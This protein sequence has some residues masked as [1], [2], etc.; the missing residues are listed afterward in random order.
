M[1][2]QVGVIKQISGL[3]VAVDQNGVSRVLK[4]GDAL[5]LG[6]V[7]KTSLAS[8]KAVV[9][10]DNGKDVTILGDESLKLDENVVAGQKP[11]TV[12]D[13]ID[14]Q[15]ALLN[16]EDL[17][18]LEETAAGGNAAAAGG[19]DG[20]SL[21]AASFDEGGHYS[22][23][24]ENFRSIGD[25]NSARGA[26][27]IGGVSGAADNAVGDAGFV[28]TTTPTVTLDPINN[29]STVVTGK[30]PNP[31]P[32]TTVTVEIPGHT[33]VTVPVNPDGTFS[34][35]TPNNEPLKPGT[36]VKVT[37]N[38]DAGNGTPATTP[39]SDV[40]TPTVTLDPINNTSTVVTGK[41]P[42]PD[43]N[44]TVTVEIPGHTPVTVPVNPDGTFSVPTPNNEP[45]KPGTEVKV[46]P[47][48]DAGNGTPAT[49]PVS[50]VVPPQVDLTPKADGTVDVV[51]HDNDATKVEISYTDNNGN[52]QT[53]TVVKNSSVGWVVDNTPGKTTAPTGAFKL[54]PNSG[55]VTISDDAT[56]DNTPVTAKATDSAGN[57]ATGE[58]TAPDK[59]TI[60]FNDD[61]DGNGTITR[62]ENYAEDGVKATATI[63][64]PNL[65]KDG[66]KIHVIGT[67]I[68][69]YYTVHKDASGNVTSVI[70]TK[71]NNVFDGNN[72]IKVGYN[73]NHYQTALGNA[74][75]ITAELEGTTLKATSS[76]KFENVKMADVEFVE[77]DKNGNVL[78]DMKTGNIDTTRRY[79]RAT[80]ALDGDINH[81]TAR[82]SLPDN[83]QD[84]DVITVKYGFGPSA[85]SLAATGGTDT[86]AYKYFLVHKAAD[87]SMTVDQIT[88]ADDKT[89]IKAGLT[90]TNGAGEK[91][92][93]DIH[94]M[95]TANYDHTHSRGIEVKITGE[96][97]S[98]VG[99]NSRYISRESMQA[100]T[101][102]FVE[103]SEELDPAIVGDGGPGSIGMKMEY[104]GLDG[105]IHHTT[106]RIKL[107]SIF[108]DGDKLTVA[109]T[110]YNK[111][112]ADTGVAKYPGDNP[113]PTT[114]KT[115][116]IHKAAD[117]TVTFDEVDASGNVIRAGIPSVNNS[118]IDVSEI[119]LYS[120]DEAGF[121]HAT[122]VDATITDHLNLNGNDSASDIA[123]YVFRETVNVKDV[124][125]TTVHDDFGS[126][127]GDISKGG[128]TDDKTPELIGKADKFATIEIFDGTHSLGTTT[129]DK[130]GNWSFTPSTPL[131]DGE[132]KFTAKATI[133]GSSKTSGEY[134][135][136]IDTHVSI[137]L[138]SVDIVADSS[139]LPGAGT[140]PF[141]VRNLTGGKMPLSDHNDILNVSGNVTGG[142][143]VLAGKGNDKISIGGYLGGIL[144]NKGTINLGESDTKLTKTVR[145][146]V[147]SDEHNREF[148]IKDANDH[149]IGRA[150]TDANGKFDGKV[151]LT[152]TISSN[153]KIS[154]EI[155]D[156]VGNTASDSKMTSHIVNSDGTRYYNNELGI[157]TD[158]D[159]GTIIGGSGNDKVVVGTSGHSSRYIT[160]GS[161]VD[162]G[163]GDNYLSVYSN[164]S[165]SKVQMGSGD[166]IVKTGFDEANNKFTKGDGYITGKSI[167]DLGD[168]NNK[169]D[170]GTNIDNSK[171]TTGSGDD[172]VEVRGYIWNASGKIAGTNEE[173]G[174]YLGDGNNKLKVGTNIDNSKVT[175][176]SGDDVIEAGGYVIN[177]KINLGDGNDT[178]TVGWI[179][180]NNNDI[181]GGAGYDKLAITNPG[182]SINL[183][184]IAN[185]A[186]N[187]EELN[188]SNKSQNTTLSVKLSDVISLTDGDNTLKITAD[189][190]DKVEFKDTGWQKGASTDGYTAYTNDTSGTTVTVEIKDEVTQ[191]M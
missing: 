69:D 128:K 39:V 130:D 140:M 91:F 96:D 12:A 126:I 151:N 90:S 103:G 57:T 137:T 122:R 159:T 143:E 149:E 108:S 35:P 141:P 176:G 174:V 61:A 120:R 150:T 134:A 125:I 45:L 80:A 44:T 78:S 171:V 178:I 13:V 11:N 139:S 114:V 142:A 1:Q 123:N 107:P 60:K 97:D 81:T 162:L 121:V 28:D 170:V 49:T 160:D 167:V 15:K 21:G 92:G 23:I 158:V 164:I 62:G 83:I 101:V 190:G 188:I 6:E 3:V 98:S 52:S 127:T 48:D 175:T 112:Y 189:A 5:Y 87:G 65:A 161:V 169:L 145:I 43:P 131:N 66:S 22:N 136:D 20:V 179:K 133:G 14:L 166:D 70:D 32:N 42:N 4:V 99:M 138:E 76:V 85:A 26:E 181:N 16:G 18:K 19:G 156:A 135:I 86:T 29:T 186:H 55:K 129:A 51:P 77:L 187:F 157:G 56:K 33:P 37:P 113:A 173:Y 117:G 100:P 165:S 177:S 132:H 17:T 180:G 154:V 27:R 68:N 146:S 110:D 36:E 102:M 94:D 184:S 59:F 2:T 53:I 168:G 104:A 191:P 172:N 119:T 74:A 34:V 58:T 163:D 54:D 88:S 116:V 182:T 183:D 73:Y 118:A 95:P 75:S 24:N 185:Q 82:I 152:R 72:G 10:M 148:V 67:G 9:S 25:L 89:P 30:V 71:G 41:V 147:S 109:I 84:G 63:S 155:T 79:D 46:T 106:A 115:F 153:E 111:I 105:D 7:V 93:I 40:T 144:G 8:S 47:N 50:D 38:D 124:T 31:D 64:I